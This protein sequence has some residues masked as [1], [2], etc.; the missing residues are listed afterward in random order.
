MIKFPQVV[1][2]ADRNSKHKSGSVFAWCPGFTFVPDVATGYWDLTRRRMPVRLPHLE[3]LG[4]ERRCSW[5][6]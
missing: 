5:D 3:N 1:R 6:D 4:H 2:A